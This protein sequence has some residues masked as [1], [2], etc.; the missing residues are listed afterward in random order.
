MALNR[1]LLGELIEKVER[2]NSKLSFGIDDVR[3]VNNVKKLMQTNM[4][5]SLEELE[6]WQKSCSGGLRNTNGT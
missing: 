6:Y 3:G 5:F 4:T 1:V 2:V